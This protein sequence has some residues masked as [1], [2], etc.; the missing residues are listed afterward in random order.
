[1]LGFGLDICGAHCSNFYI[2]TRV[3]SGA[4]EVS[5]TRASYRKTSSMYVVGSI[6]GD[7]YK[8]LRYLG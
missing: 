7:T 3:P 6:L 1:M 8:P 5:A 4:S 2:M